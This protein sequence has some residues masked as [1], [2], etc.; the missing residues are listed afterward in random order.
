MLKPQDRLYFI[1]IPK[2]AGTTLIPHLDAHFH[3]D[4]ICPAQLW[5]ELLLLPQETLPR[6]RLFRGHFGAKGLD[7]FLPE[8]PMR[9]TM[10][11]HPV[12]LALSTYQFIVRE[13][14]TFDHRL[15]KKMSFADFLQHP[16]ARLGITNKQV[17]NLCFE[18]RYPP[19]TLRPMLLAADRWMGE[20]RV[21][22]RT[23]QEQLD[24]ALAILHEC[25]FF[26]LVERFDESMALLSWIFGWPPTRQ[27]QKL[28]VAPPLSFEQPPISEQ[29]V[30]QIC[31]CN[32]LDLALYEV[33]EKLF[34]KQLAAM[35]E[36]LKPYAV[37]GEK[38]PKS[39]SED[40]ELTY[41][42]LERHYQHHWAAQTSP[43]RSSIQITF[44]E[45]LQGSGWHR[46]ETATDGTLYC[47]TGPGTVSTLDIDLVVNGDLAVTFLVLDVASRELL[48]SVQLIINGHP[49]VLRPITKRSL[50]P[51]YYRAY[52]SKNI[53]P[54]GSGKGNIRLTFQVAATLTLGSHAW[55]P[56]SVGLAINWIEVCPSHQALPE[57]TLASMLKDV[58]R[59]QIVRRW[60]LQLPWIA[61]WLRILY[62]YLCVASKR[63]SERFLI[64]PRKLVKAKGKGFQ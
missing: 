2:T 26:G 62:L 47:W 37:A 31:A 20:H 55:D 12:P 42:L 56:R 3:V 59:P 34:E 50:V 4:E 30:A 14:G 15:V 44:A 24:Q 7:S 27:V 5:P 21:I 11:R 46:R 16:K 28:M 32:T 54:S 1:H 23:S 61:S 49:V 19:D 39:F 18:L 8:L 60:I 41:M 9:I 64:G 45:P 6:Y 25:V 58:R 33:A 35:M 53:L 43:K 22:Y 40:P 29:L 57:A 51:R 52:V 10:L 17:R 36:G 48:D 13:P 63:L 38:V